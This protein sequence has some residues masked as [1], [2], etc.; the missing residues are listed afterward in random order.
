MNAGEGL[1]ALSEPPKMDW[2]ERRRIAATLYKE[3]S[4]QSLYALKSGNLFAGEKDTGRKNKV[5]LA[6]RRALQSKITVSVMFAMMCAASILILT[7]G[8]YYLPSSLTPL[9]FDSTIIT[10]VLVVLFSL[11]WI[12]GLQVALPFLSSQALTL[13]RSLPMRE[14][15]IEG[16]TI[17]AF[18]RLFDLPL[19]TAIVVLPL[20]VGVALG[21]WTAALASIPAVLLTEIFS[22]YLSLLTARFFALRVSGSSGGSVL[23][24]ATRWI[25]LVLWTIPSLIITIFIAFSL[26]IL[27]T[28]GQWETS[29]PM[30]LKLLFSIFPF[31]YSYIISA[32]AIRP[33][34]D[35]SFILPWIIAAV[36]YACL[37]FF[38]ARWLMKA[39]LE[40]GRTQ[41]TVT[42]ATPRS[43]RLIATSPTIAIIKKDLRIASRTPAYAFLLLL[44]MLDAFILGLFT[45]VGNPNPVMA[46]HYA[47]AAVTVAVLL[48]TFFGPVFFVTEVMGFSLTK[49]LPITQRTLILG[50]STLISIVY[51]VSFVLVAVLVASRVHDFEAF[52]FFAVAELPAVV[53]ASLLEINILL[54]RADKTGIPI[55]SLYSGAWWATIVVIPGLIVAGLPLIIYTVLAEGSFYSYSLA[56]MALSSLILLTCTSVAVLWRKD[57]PL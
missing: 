6:E 29:S 24:M 54:W 9:Y 18:I 31:P 39:P 12:T 16:I 10:M 20:T 36:L 21:S 7:Q 23:N 57:R 41:V 47:K 45:Y 28:L 38:A 14:E 8:Q 15:D 2:K 1:A 43:S 13:L 37:A 33:T 49:T 44:P 22:L 46:D 11:V 19:I 51:V 4:F 3:L 32:L 25:Y 50:K 53:A 56:A 34:L 30:A 27:G 26:S 42:L 40:L 17:Y 5:E 55:S 35:I 48:A 52:L